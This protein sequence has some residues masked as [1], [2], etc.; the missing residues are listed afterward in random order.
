VIAEPGV[1]PRVLVLAGLDLQA[2]HDDV[3]QAVAGLAMGIEPAAVAPRVAVQLAEGVHVTVLAQPGDEQEL[4][5]IVA[6]AVRR[7]DA[8]GARAREGLHLPLA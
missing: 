8:T 6:L 4:R 5:A 1:A 2:A 7:A 3:V